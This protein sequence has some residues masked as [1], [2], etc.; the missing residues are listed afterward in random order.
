MPAVKKTFRKGKSAKRTSNKSTKTKKPKASKVFKKKVERVIA[1][2]AEVKHIS[3][4]GAPAYYNSAIAGA[5]DINP[6]L[7]PMFQGT[8]DRERIGSKVNF[9]SFRLNICISQA[10]YAL[11]TDLD[12]PVLVRLLVLTYK[13]GKYQPDFTTSRIVTDVNESLLHQDA[14]A[15]A[16]PYDGSILHHLFPVNNDLF[17]VIKDISFTILPN[18]LNDNTTNS[19]TTALGKNFRTFS[20]NVP[21]PSHLVYGEDINQYPNNFAPFFSVGYCYPD[22]DLADVLNTGLRVTWE[23]RL[24]YTDE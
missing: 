7:P 15:P 8:K 10:P 14:S 18:E 5:G 3:T 6:I 23:S 21:G 12:R 20:V 11:L 22:G 17:T 2:Q 13:R 16:Q 4:W 24:S 19:Q 9:R 1:S